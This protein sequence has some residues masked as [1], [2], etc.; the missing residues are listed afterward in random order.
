MSMSR[1]SWTILL[2]IRLQ[3]G[4]AEIFPGLYLAD[5]QI[6]KCPMLVGIL[7]DVWR[8]KIEFSL[9]ECQFQLLLRSDLLPRTG[10]RSNLENVLQTLRTFRQEWHWNQELLVSMID[11]DGKH[12]FGFVVVRYLPINSL[13]WTSECSAW[14]HQVSLVERG[15]QHVLQQH[16]SIAFRSSAQIASDQSFRSIRY[17]DSSASGSESNS[18]D[19]S[20]RRLPNIDT[21]LFIVSNLRSTD[22]SDSIQSTRI[23]WFRSIVSSRPYCSRCFSLVHRW[24]Q[25]R[26]RWKPRTP[27]LPANHAFSDSLCGGKLWSSLF[28]RQTVAWSAEEHEYYLLPIRFGSLSVVFRDLLPSRWSLVFLERGSELHPFTDLSATTAIRDE[29]I[30]NGNVST[31][32]AIATTDPWMS[33][34]RSIDYTTGGSGRIH[35]R[36]ERLENTA[37]LDFSNKVS[38]VLRNAKAGWSVVSANSLHLPQDRDGNAWGVFG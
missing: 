18:C 19:S 33:S 27:I 20:H 30:S 8:K 29:S 13:T 28:R 14:N 32:H 1:T 37:E 7:Q 26:C 21:R 16:F 5:F 36:L 17:D 9:C 35:E 12:E 23:L 25:L 15:H 11:R 10:Q 22:Q 2:F 24:I 3:T 38:L 34:T 31:D 6:E 4:W